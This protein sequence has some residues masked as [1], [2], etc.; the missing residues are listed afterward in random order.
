MGGQ[1]ARS[2]GLVPNVL[3]GEVQPSDLL[4]GLGRGRGG[5][6][7]LLRDGIAGKAVAFL[8]VAHRA[9][10]R[11]DPPAQWGRRDGVGT[12]DRF[13]VDA[14]MAD[15]NADAEL[16]GAAFDGVGDRTE[17]VEAEAAGEAAGAGSSRFA[18]P[19]NDSQLAAASPSTASTPAMVMSGSARLPRLGR[20]TVLSTGA[21]VDLRSARDDAVSC[22]GSVAASCPGGRP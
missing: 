15:A 7:A 14:G 6:R 22:R 10:F 13:A 18:V 21:P 11:G 12:R 1:L 17:V 16:A 2:E 9:C 20:I 5:A 4:D 19:P 8:D 3:T